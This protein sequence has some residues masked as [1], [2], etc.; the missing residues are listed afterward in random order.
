MNTFVRRS[1]VALFLVAGIAMVGASG[2]PED[3]GSAEADDTTTEVIGISK[4]VA[5]P[6]LDAIE[7]GIIDEL[8]DLGHD[9]LEFD[10]QNANGDM[11]TAASIATKFRNDNVDLAIGIATPTAQAL[12]NAIDDVPVVFAAVTD[13]VGAGLISSTDAGEGNIT[14]SSDVA[15]ME[16]QFEL[17]S[18]LVDVETVG[19][20]YAGGES[21]AVSMAETARATAEAMG[22]DFVEATVVNS[23]EV[24]SATQS[25]IDRVDAIYV[26]LDNTVVSAISA[27]TDVAEG[28]GVPVISADTTS[29]ENGGVLLALGFNYY[30]FGR[31]TGRLVADILD[32]TDP[33]SIPTLF[34]T[35][36]ADLDLL[37]NLDVAEELGISIPEDLR[38][39]AS[40]VIEDGEISR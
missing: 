32:G 35:D 11:S 19:H 40:I 37:I 34:L 1:V 12:A 14:G 7:K 26:S 2:A 33:A 21:N 28:A 9:D 20:V 13:P 17:M 3:S 27:L 39:D 25:I 23:S 15:P 18:R 6:A 36:P 8:A 24:R 30:K 22:L 16:A 29:A 4:I 31:A 5:H 38:S 10:L